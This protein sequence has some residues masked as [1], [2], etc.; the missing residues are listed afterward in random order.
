MTVGLRRVL[1][2]ICGG[3][4]TRGR[5]VWSKTNLWKPVAKESILVWLIL[6][7][8]IMISGFRKG[9]NREERYAEQTAVH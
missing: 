9:R 4:V 8:S 7:I 6:F 1:F 3:A 5:A 2:L